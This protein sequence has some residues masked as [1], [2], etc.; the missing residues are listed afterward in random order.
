MAVLTAGQRSGIVA[1]LMRWWS[2]LREACPFTKLDL[3]AT[4]DA[5]DAWVDTNAAAFNLALPLVFRNGATPLQK[6]LVLCYVA[7]RRAQRD[8]ANVPMPGEN[9]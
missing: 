5:A 2:L 8:G 6:T 7:I 9:Q 4:V 3:S 1:A